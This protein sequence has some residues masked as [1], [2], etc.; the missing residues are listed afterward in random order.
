MSVAPTWALG[1]DADSTDQRRS[2]KTP[3]GLGPALLA[4]QLPTKPS[5][6]FRTQVPDG[7]A[8]LDTS[9]G[10][11][12]SLAPRELAQGLVL[13]AQAW[14][15]QHMVSLLGWGLGVGRAETRAWG[16]PGPFT[17]NGHPGPRLRAQ[18]EPG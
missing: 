12:L 7:P 17:G 5:L 3:M 13:S 10:P 8:L 9:P 11:T 4:A 14:L 1:W 15:E 2:H 18:Q 16:S 6:P